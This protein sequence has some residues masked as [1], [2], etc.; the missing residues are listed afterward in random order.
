[1]SCVFGLPVRMRTQWL[2]H[3]LESDLLD[4]GVRVAPRSLEGTYRT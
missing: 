2:S 3:R 4:R 1:M